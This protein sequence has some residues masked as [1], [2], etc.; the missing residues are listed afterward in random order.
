MGSQIP[1]CNACTRKEKTEEFSVDDKEV[2]KRQ[3]QKDKIEK[4]VKSSNHQS[5]SDTKDKDIFSVSSKKGSEYLISQT[6]EKETPKPELIKD[7]TKE[8]KDE[9]KKGFDKNTAKILRTLYK[10]N[11]IKKI[12]KKFREMLNKRKLNIKK[13]KEIQFPVPN[14]KDPLLS[15][16]K[17]ENSGIKDEY[18]DIKLKVHK[19]TNINSEK[20]D[21]KEKM[22][23]SNTEKFNSNN[24]ASNKRVQYYDESSQAKK[25]NKYSNNTSRVDMDSKIDQEENKDPTNLNS[26]KKKTDYYY[27][28]KKTVDNNTNTKEFRVK[29]Q[30]EEKEK[31]IPGGKFDMISLKADSIHGEKSQSG[32]YF[33][34]KGGKEPYRQTLNSLKEPDKNESGV[35]RV[36][37]SLLWNSPLEDSKK[38]I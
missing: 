14:S 22:N 13:L 19:E 12:Q 24:N 17:E 33:S 36:N 7:L 34:N 28:H 8:P 10:A 38:N 35:K 3:K 29:Q 4:M 9:K 2:A 32:F 18:S 16:I 15:I 1:G 30:L 26:V 27:G 21:K 20:N 23:S 6:D 11:N 31:F 37:K 5:T 25:N